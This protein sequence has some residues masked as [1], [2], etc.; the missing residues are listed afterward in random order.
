M[1][2]LV[3]FNPTFSSYRIP[4]ERPFRWSYASLSKSNSSSTAT[5]TT[6]SWAYFALVIFF[7]LH[8]HCIMGLKSSLGMKCKVWVCF[9]SEWCAFCPLQKKSLFFLQGAHLSMWTCSLWHTQTGWFDFFKK[10]K[11]ASFSASRSNSAKWSKSLV[12]STAHC[13]LRFAFSVDWEWCE[14]K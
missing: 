2:L 12:S 4:S 5:Q 10:Y 7:F 8:L 6:A 1:E 14:R 9:E 13:W 3:M 11:L